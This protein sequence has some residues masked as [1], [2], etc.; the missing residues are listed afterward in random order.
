MSSWEAWNKVSVNVLVLSTYKL[1]QERIII[2]SSY[3]AM[4]NK[5]ARLKAADDLEMFI[6]YQ[7]F[8]Y[9]ANKFFEPEWQ[10]DETGLN[11][12]KINTNYP[13]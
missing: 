8:L 12:S 11:L 4:E 13:S 7:L 5:L 1:I 6:W 3:F 2:Q 10:N 9:P